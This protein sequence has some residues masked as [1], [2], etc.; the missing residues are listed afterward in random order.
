MAHNGLRV[1]SK[2]INVKT[3]AAVL[4]AVNTAGIYYL[5]RLKNKRCSEF[6]GAA[7]LRLTF[8]SITRKAY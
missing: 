7:R 3:A 6:D 8:A 4:T 5:R 2:G 1:V